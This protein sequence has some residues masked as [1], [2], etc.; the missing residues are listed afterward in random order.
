MPRY[1]TIADFE[2]CGLPPG[3]I[4][5]ISKGEIQM[6]LDRQSAH[7]DTYLGAKV[8]LPL[9]AP[10]DPQLVDAVC[11]LAAWRIMCRRG[12]N[13]DNNGDAVVRQGWVDAIAWLTRVANGQARINVVQSAPASL[14]PNVTTNADRGYS[15][16]TD[17]TDAPIVG[18]GLGGWGV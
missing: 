9:A 17:Q 18:G 12:F 6:H 1:A 3:A 14:Q 2:A 13:P 8:T 11:Q 15:P 7:A 5:D 16:R 4:G 10:Y